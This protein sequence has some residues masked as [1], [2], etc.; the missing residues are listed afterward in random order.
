MPIYEY[1]CEACGNVLEILQSST[2]TQSEGF[3]PHC[4]AVRNLTKIFSLTAAPQGSGSDSF[5]S[6]SSG[7]GGCGCGGGGFS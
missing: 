6:S 1:K 2:K 4:N 3:C 7:G 5:A